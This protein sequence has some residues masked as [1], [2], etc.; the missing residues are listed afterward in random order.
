MENLYDKF[1]KVKCF[2]FD[3]D[4]VM[5]DGGLLILESGE[6]LRTFFVKDGWAIN[7]ALK[8]GFPIAVISAGNGNGVQKRLEYL[9]IPYI[10]MGTKSKLDKYEELKATLNL[11]D[12]EIAYMGDD[13][14][15]LQVLKRVG[16]PCCP[17]DAVDDILGVCSFISSYNGGKGAVRELIEKVLRIQDKWN[18]E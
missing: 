18:I 9:N 17:A 8:E 6:H 7:K 15:D 2:I 3:V 12:E 1:A 13:I 10:F 4:G 11:K 16:L 5:T 14:P